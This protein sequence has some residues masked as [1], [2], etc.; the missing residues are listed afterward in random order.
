MRFWL[1]ERAYWISLASWYH[2]LVFGVWVPVMAALSLRR[3]RAQP[4][5]MPLNRLKH[6][7]SS[8]FILVAFGALSLISARSQN[9]DLLR[10]VLLAPQWSMPAAVVFYAGA[11]MAMRPRWRRA[12]ERGE[13]IVNLYMPQTRVERGWWIAVSMLA[14]IS[15]ELTWRGMQPILLTALTGSVGMGVLG[16]AALFGLGHAPQGTRS[17]VVIGI[18]SLGFNALV[19]LSGSLYLAMAV[20]IAYDL[21]AGLTYGKLGRELGYEPK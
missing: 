5:G 8:A 3:V 1:L 19:W 17:A 15:E 18:F 11:V 2:L 10:P 16:S 12:V 13:R 20:H 21:T 9:I 4:A 7:Q 14:G 6:L